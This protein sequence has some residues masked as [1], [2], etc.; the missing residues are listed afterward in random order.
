MQNTALSRRDRGLTMAVAVAAMLVV[1]VPTPSP[2]PATVLTTGTTSAAART[3]GTRLFRNG[4]RQRKA[5]THV[6]GCHCFNRLGALE[7]A[8]AYAHRRVS[9]IVGGN[10][11]RIYLRI[12]DTAVERDRTVG[13][14][15]AGSIKQL[16]DE[17]VRKVSAD[18]SP[19]AV[20]IDGIEP[21]RQ[22]VR[23]QGE[24]GCLASC[25]RRD[26]SKRYDDM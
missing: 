7:A 4:S 22:A 6:F 20:T 25:D 14:G 18:G 5:G 21:V 9:G 17:W 24:I 16:H 12:G 8:Q 26:E 15:P 13:N 10:D 2:A 19:L 3:S 11:G 23:G 1:L